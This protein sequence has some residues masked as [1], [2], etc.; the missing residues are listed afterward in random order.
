MRPVR[1]HP[2][3]K[4]IKGDRGPIDSPMQDERVERITHPA[5]VDGAGWLDRYRDAWHVLKLD[6]TD[7]E[8]PLPND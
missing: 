8:K 6:P 1:S 3:D 4:L 2:A 7:P 5:T